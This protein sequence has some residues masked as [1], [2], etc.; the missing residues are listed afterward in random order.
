MNYGLGGATLTQPGALHNFPQECQYRMLKESL[1][2]AVFLG[3]GAMDT[4]LKNYNEQKYIQTYL[5]LIEEVRNLPSKP[6]I[7]LTVP[8]FSCKHN[9]INMYST[10]HMRGGSTHWLPADPKLCNEGDHAIPAFETAFKVAKQAGIPESRI[11]NTY[12]HLRSGKNKDVMSGDAIHP[13]KKGQEILGKVAYNMLINDSDIKSR[14]A[15]LA[16]GLDEDYNKA[17]E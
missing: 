1:P 7:F 11:L 3:F 8:L 10:A 15:K 9:I 4:L 16:Q 12:Y 6:I 14:V 13:N 2:H 17:V 5:S